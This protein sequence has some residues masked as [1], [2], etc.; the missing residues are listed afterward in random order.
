MM[1]FRLRLHAYRLLELLE[2][3]YWK[4][5]AC[6]GCLANGKVTLLVVGPPKGSAPRPLPVNVNDNYPCTLQLA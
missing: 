6:L 5:K 3:C 2:A 4:G 1:V